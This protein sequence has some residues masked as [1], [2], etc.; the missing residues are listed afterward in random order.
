MLSRLDDDRHGVLSASPVTISAATVV[1]AVFLAFALDPD[2]I[3]KMTCVGVAV[4]IL[5]D[6]V[7]VRM[8]LMPVM[9]MKLGAAGRTFPRRRATQRSDLNQDAHH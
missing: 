1:G 9:M 5:V 3:V 8:I 4:G 7:A 2:V 6:I